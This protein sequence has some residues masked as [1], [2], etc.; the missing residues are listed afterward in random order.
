MTEL[1]EIFGAEMRID[2]GFYSV[3]LG[4]TTRGFYTITE[5]KRKETIE[6]LRRLIEELERK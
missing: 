4:N 2:N 5:A 3:R 6:T 1:F